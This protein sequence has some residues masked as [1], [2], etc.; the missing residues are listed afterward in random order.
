[1]LKFENYTPENLKKYAPYIKNCPY[2]VNDVSVGSFFMWNG[3]V[4]LKFAVHNGAFISVQ[5]ICGE[6]SFSYP[7]GGNNGNDSN[8]G[9]NGNDGNNGNG[10]DESE[11]LNE[12]VDYVK[13]NDLPL[14]FYGVTEETLEKIRKNPL[15][16]NIMFNYERKW[17]DYVYSAEEIS[18]FKG[19]KFSGQ[20]NH[21]NKFKTLYGEPDF[22]PMKPE[23][24]PQ[25]NDMLD[26][27]AKEHPSDA[28]EENEE[29]IHTKELLAEFF[30]FDLVGG[31]LFVGD[32]PVSVTIGEIQDKNL[33]I[34][35]E[36]ALK[37]Y[38][39]A[40]P[41]TF[42]RFVNYCLSLNPELETV[43]R[44][45]DADD[46][47]L[48]TSKQQYNPIKLVNKYLVKVN[49]PL[50]NLAATPV[51]TD[52]N[53]VL[54]EITEKDKAD[55]RALCTD[56]ENNALWGY[57]YETDASITGEITDDTFFD[58][59]NFDR[60]IGEGI[61]FAIREKTVDNRLIGEVIV[62]NFTYNGAA[63]AGVRVAKGFQGK[64][65]GKAAYKLVCDWAANVLGVKLKAKCYKKNEKSRKTIIDCGFDQT[66]E[67]EEF[68]YF[69]Y[70]DSIRHH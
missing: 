46:A 56:K 9:N 37:S 6:P 35:V 20:R 16:S 68:Y 30:D 24:L 57:D 12:I 63:E 34:H 11:A 5:D 22:R 47:G 55:Y 32:K 44:E 43:N 38:V 23:F 2:N 21:I 17:S 8:T 59:V 50:Q 31:A 27:Y 65:Y 70:R 40:Y 33:I 51:L 42:N 62:Y 49:S 14:K 45:D 10:G 58:V 36:K 7:F 25:I 54:S 41:T 15:F 1:M 69:K 29:F 18:T 3:G 60:S 67:D 39:G 19:K 26:L 48:R 28:Y 61:S 64:G 66:S 52:G 4:N 13:A 53:V